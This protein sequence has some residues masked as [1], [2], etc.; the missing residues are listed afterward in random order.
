MKPGDPMMVAID[1]LARLVP[2]GQLASV[3]GPV[4]FLDHVSN[5][6]A[7][8]EQAAQQ[9]IA[10][11]RA[12]AFRE[13][14]HEFNQIAIASDLPIPS[15]FYLKALNRVASMVLDAEKAIT[16]DFDAAAKR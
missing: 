4:A 15:A 10:E 11:A 1:R 5:Y 6:V 2:D 13:A 16:I 9:R 12:A 8:H 3:M 14:L 7:E